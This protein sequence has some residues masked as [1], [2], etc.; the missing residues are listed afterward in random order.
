MSHNYSLHEQT[1]L[2]HSSTIHDSRPS[3]CIRNRIDRWVVSTYPV[4]RRTEL[5]TLILQ[6]AQSLYRIYHLTSP[7][8]AL[9]GDS[10]F[11]SFTYTAL[12]APFGVDSPL[13]AASPL[14]ALPKALPLLLSMLIFSALSAIIFS[15]LVLVPPFSALASG[16]VL[17]VFDD[18]SL[19]PSP[20]SFE[21]LPKAASRRILIDTTREKNRS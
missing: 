4:P 20:A 2:P 16:V 11:V 9:G 12:G 13:A 5:Y 19:A 1:H 14:P 17:D 10:A 18:A 7:L 21:L 3:G 6:T 8:G 15:A